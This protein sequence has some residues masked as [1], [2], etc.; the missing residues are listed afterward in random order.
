MPNQ[1]LHTYIVN[2]PNHGVAQLK[3][4]IKF[5][6]IYHKMILRLHK[7]INGTKLAGH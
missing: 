4:I 2:I 7:A 3:G 5:Q 1:P 6:G